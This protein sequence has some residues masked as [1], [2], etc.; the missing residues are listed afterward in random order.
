MNTRTVPASNARVAP[1]RRSSDPADFPTNKTVYAMRDI[2][3]L[4][5][6]AAAHGD[7]VGELAAKVLD[8]PLP[9][10]TMRKVYKLIGLCRTYGDDRT[11]QACRKALD[12][13]AIDV[14]VVGRILD[15]ALEAETAEQ[16]AKIPSNV[17]VAVGRFARDDTQ[18]ATNKARP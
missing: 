16:T 9:W 2:G 14:N 7:A 8:H 4:I 15:R 11:N 18:F 3:R 10:T 1:G 5:S 6:D 12:A 13:E 17:I